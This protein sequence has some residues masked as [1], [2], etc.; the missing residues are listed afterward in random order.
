MN[1]QTFFETVKSCL[2]MELGEEYLVD[3]VD[4][5]K[6]N[7]TDWKALSILRLFPEKDSFRKAV[8]VWPVYQEYQNGKSLKECV[9]I[10]KAA[11]ENGDDRVEILSLK[12]RMAKWEEVKD[13]I[14]PMVVPYVGNDCFLNTVPHRP[15]LDLAVCYYAAVNLNGIDGSVK[16]TNALADLWGVKEEDIYRQAFRNMQ[17]AGYELIDIRELLEEVMG[18]DKEMAGPPMYVVTN[19]VKCFGAAVIL[20]GDFLENCS[21]RLKGSFYLL[22]SSVHE[23]VAV[24]Y[25]GRITPGELQM[26]VKE[27]KQGV[28][29]TEEQLGDTIYYYDHKSKEIQIARQGT[30]MP[31]AG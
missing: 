24:P 10:L 18:E 8:G 20:D 26:V 29:A 17:R 14:Q 30:A 27:I 6:N 5:P 19:K 22:P 9:M 4:L 13:R 7:R 21:L 25:D 28:V 15:Y 16:V 31:L 2:Q 12:E 23:M 11:F 1:Y 3:A